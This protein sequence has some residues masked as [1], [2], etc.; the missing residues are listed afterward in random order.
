[1]PFIYWERLWNSS[2]SSFSC[3]VHPIRIFISESRFQAS[4][5]HTMAS[6]VCSGAVPTSFRCVSLYQ[7]PTVP[8][9]TPPRFFFHLLTTPSRGSILWSIESGS[10]GRGEIP[11][12]WYS[13]RAARHDSV[14]LRSRPYSLDER[15]S[16]DRRGIAP[17]PTDWLWNG[18]HSGVFCFLGPGPS[19]PS[20]CLEPPVQGIFCFPGGMR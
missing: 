17:V 14:K 1:M 20:R 4:T 16:C 19:A 5:T 6:T 12:R 2:I 3:W 7:S 10:S 13:P 11:H 8:A 9:R 18:I 15:R